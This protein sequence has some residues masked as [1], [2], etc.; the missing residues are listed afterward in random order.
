[1]GLGLLFTTSNGMAI[2]FPA[3]DE[4]KLPMNITGI[5]EGSGLGVVRFVSVTIVDLRNLQY[6]P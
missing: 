2:K 3:K 6:Q 4:H 1:M 5:P